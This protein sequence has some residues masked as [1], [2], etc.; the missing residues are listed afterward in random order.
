LIDLFEACVKGEFKETKVKLTDE[1]LENQQLKA[2]F[3]YKE[4]LVT[5]FDKSVCLLDFKG[6]TVAFLEIGETKEEGVQILK[7]GKNSEP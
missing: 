6:N 5:H 2:I 7:I 1:R 4:T 3:L